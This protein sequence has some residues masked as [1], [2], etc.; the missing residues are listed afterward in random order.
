VLQP[1]GSETVHQARSRALATGAP[2]LL[3]DEEVPR[4]GVQLTRAP[5]RAL[6]RRLELGMETASVD[7]FSQVGQLYLR[8]SARP[9]START[10]PL[11]VSAWTALPSGTRALL[12]R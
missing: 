3:Y 1:D 12:A 2:L 6:D 8:R 9:R 10:K 7:C 5:A 11:S 4:E